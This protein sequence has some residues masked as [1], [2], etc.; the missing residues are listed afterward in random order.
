MKRSRFVVMRIHSEYLPKYAL[1]LLRELE[2]ETI[3]IRKTFVPKYIKIG[4]DRAA[5]QRRADQ[6]NDKLVE[7]GRFLTY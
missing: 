6:L 1:T 4:G 2:L 3:A 5:F 7:R